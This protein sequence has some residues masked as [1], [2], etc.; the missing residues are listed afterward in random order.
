[1]MS[2]TTIRYQL[3]HP[4]GNHPLLG[5][6]VGDC[7]VDDTTLYSLMTDGRPL[8]IHQVWASDAAAVAQPWSDRV[9]IHRAVSLS[10]PGLAAALIRPDGVVVWAAE[11]RARADP[12]TLVAALETWFGPARSAGSLAMPVR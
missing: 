7:V 11:P 5:G 2:G 4:T 9:H 3:A 1:M 10:S 12:A 6:H 8:L